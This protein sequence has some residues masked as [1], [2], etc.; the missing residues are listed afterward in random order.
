MSTGIESGTQPLPDLRT[1]QRGNC[2]QLSFQVNKLILPIYV[3]R[4]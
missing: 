3:S 2:G 1:G 4:A